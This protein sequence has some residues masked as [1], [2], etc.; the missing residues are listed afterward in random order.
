MNLD[1]FKSQIITT[2]LPR[3]VYQ[4]PGGGTSSIES[5]SENG[6]TY[7]RGKSKIY[8]SFSDMYSAYTHFKKKYITSNDLKKFA[9]DVFD[10]DARPAGHSCNCTFLFTALYKLGL[11]GALSGEGVRGN[12]FGAEIL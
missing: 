1:S 5:I 9:P 6:I 7:K 3:D 2:V 8:I 4:N 12:P 11:A 10:S